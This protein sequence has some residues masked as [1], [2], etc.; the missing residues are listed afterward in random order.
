MTPPRKIMDKYYFEKTFIDDEIMCVP[1]G[2]FYF[3]VSDEIL[4]TTKYF[5]KEDLM[6]NIKK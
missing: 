1:F 6:K 3:S 2:I 4:S 5:L